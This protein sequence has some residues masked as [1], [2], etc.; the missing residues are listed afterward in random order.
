MQQLIQLTVDGIAVIRLQGD[1]DHHAA[2]RIREDISQAIYQG[3]VHA[4]VWNLGDLQFMDSAGIGL[5]LGRMR[6]LA[7]I[8]GQTVILNP[9][10]TMQKIFQFSG[11][12]KYIWQGTEDEV[13][14]TLGGI[15]NG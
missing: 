15:L 12:S 9:S 14:R 5:I 7:P 1:L 2:N 11:L 13:I 4:I 8:N 3:S 10:A 6:D